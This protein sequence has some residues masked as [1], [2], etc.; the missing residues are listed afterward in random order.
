MRLQKY[1]AACGVASRRKS[2]KLIAEGRV[3]VDG[4]VVLDPAIQVDETHTVCFDGKEIMP[5]KH[6]YVLL[7]KPSGIVST[8]ADRHASA[9]ILDLIQTDKRLYSVGRLDKNTEGLLIL[10]NDGDLTYRLTHPKFHIVKTY[11]AKVKGHV[12]HAALT[13]LRNGVDIPLD[14]A[15]RTYMTKPADVVIISENRGS[16]TLEIT[17]AEGKKRQVRKMCDAVGHPVVALRRTAIGSLT[18]PHLKT[19]AWRPLT[20]EEVKTLMTEAVHD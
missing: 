10:T 9:K 2:E 14:D 16:T 8:S 15:G 1:M 20:D 19:G 13:A 3:T 12:N 18:D 11:Q 7:N 5:E 4:E 6:V 17:I